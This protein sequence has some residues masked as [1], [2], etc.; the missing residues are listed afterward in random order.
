MEATL[1]RMRDQGL[2]ADYEIREHPGADGAPEHDI[3]LSFDPAL[4]EEARSR[5]IERVI[6]A[7]VAAGAHVAIT[8]VS[9]PAPAAPHADAEPAQV[10]GAA[11][12][13]PWWR[14]LFG[15]GPHA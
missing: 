15:G 6:V 1:R 12:S 5:T 2:V 10:D 3:R 14:R 4:S 9:A 8:A 11:A 13:M 7:A